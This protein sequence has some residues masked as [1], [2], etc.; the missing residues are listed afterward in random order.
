MHVSMI[1]FVVV[2]G[3]FELYKKHVGLDS[4]LKFILIAILNLFAITIIAP[5]AISFLGS[6]GVS[7]VESYL[8]GSGDDQTRV[9]ISIAIYSFFLFLAHL[10]L[11]NDDVNNLFIVM[12]FSVFGMML[13]FPGATGIPGT[14]GFWIRAR[15]SAYTGGTV[16]VFFTPTES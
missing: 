16:D 1:F 10:K 2:F 11:K 14:K 4:V 6:L 15:I 8:E 13:A 7:R 12:M 3:T 9:F 5:F